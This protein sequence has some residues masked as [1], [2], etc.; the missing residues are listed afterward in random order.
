M[1][2][3]SSMHGVVV[4]K[5]PAKINLHLRIVSRLADGY[6]ELRTIFQALELH[7]RLEAVIADETSVQVEGDA[8]TGPV[9]DNLV[10]RAVRAF[11]DTVPD[12][13][14]A[15][16]RLVKRIPAGAGLGGGSSDAAAALRAINTLAGSPLPLARLRT[17]GGSLG[18][19]VPFFLCG[20]PRAYGEGRGERLA[21]LAA[22]PSAH[23]LL[24]DPGFPVATRD[25][26]AWWDAR[27]AQGPVGRGIAGMADGARGTGAAGG[28]RAPPLG[29]SEDFASLAGWAR[30][31]FEDVVFE[32]HPELRAIER[33]L[34]GAG[35]I[36][37]M[38][39]GS[40]SCVYGIFDDP[41]RAEAAERHVRKVMPAA[42]VLRTRT[43][44]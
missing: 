38:L 16:L 25:A 14:H 18:S 3:P 27:H 21:P 8:Q 26:F 43:V 12:A 7:D 23:V 20:S 30:N 42:R 17:I 1:R 10:L 29:A 41:A 19:D 13:P 9:E 39:S 32:R 35:A 40:G 34:H 28:E 6:H 2:D 31:D 37:A 44:E 24:V 36:L 4:E 15:R 11:R 33:A 22:S 5:A